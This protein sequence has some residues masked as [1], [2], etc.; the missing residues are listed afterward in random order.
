MIVFR[1]ACGV[2]IFVPR[3][4]Y[5]ENPLNCSIDQVIARLADFLDGQ[6]DLETAP[7]QNSSRRIITVRLVQA[8]G[9]TLIVTHQLSIAPPADR[10]WAVSEYRSKPR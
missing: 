4:R 5:R 3:W 8:L 2:G 6:A 7:N 10:A 1:S 9:F